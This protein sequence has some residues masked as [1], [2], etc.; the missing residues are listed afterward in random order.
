[1]AKRRTI[2]SICMLLVAALALGGCAKNVG[3]SPP[4][5]DE[6]PEI[7]AF[8]PSSNS[9]SVNEPDDLSFS[10]DASDKEDSHLSYYWNGD[11]TA[12]GPT[13]TYHGS[14]DSNHTNETMDVTVTV[15]DSAGNSDSM[16]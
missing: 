16:S 6:P 3:K 8:S 10:I 13:W 14:W 11:A 7:T 1:M 15:R 9:P 2:V 12:G 5:I 4:Q